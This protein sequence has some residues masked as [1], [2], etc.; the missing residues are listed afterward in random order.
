[1]K[2]TYISDSPQFGI[3]KL[4]STSTTNTTR[5]RLDMKNICGCLEIAGE[6]Q[7]K[8]GTNEEKKVFCPASPP[9]KEFQIL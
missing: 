9:K 2:K 7:A 8:M 3:K 6:Q 4:F 1:M 5:Q